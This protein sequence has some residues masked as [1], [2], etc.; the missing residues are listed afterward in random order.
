MAEAFVHPTAV[1]DEGAVLG[2][3]TKV[4][5][6]V[7]VCGGATVGERCIFGQ[8]VFVGPGVVVGN[9]V[10]VQSV[11]SRTF[12]TISALKVNSPV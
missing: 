9:G 4:W 7:H 10:K 12:G 11:I 3:G 8:S 2:E 6:F 1:V 5:H